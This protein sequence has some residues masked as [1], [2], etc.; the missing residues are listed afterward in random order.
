MVWTT[1][2]NVKERWPDNPVQPAP[3]D[4]KLTLYIGD[5]EAQI[6]S[7]YP[8]L[9]D[10]IDNNTLSLTVIQNATA[11][12]IIEY[13]MRGSNPYTQESQGYTG[14]SSRSVTFE[15]RWRKNLILSETDLDAFMPRNQGKAFSVDM[16]PKL[17]TPNDDC[18][19]WH[20]IRIIG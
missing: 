7:R 16:A 10:R 20:T 2:E 18:G 1:P 6:L 4:A 3:S 9:Q 17:R 8:N 11:S 13:V 12:W 14:A 15:S 19:P 5:I